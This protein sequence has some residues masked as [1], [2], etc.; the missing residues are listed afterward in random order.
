MI[1][2][3]RGREGGFTMVEL[4]IATAVLGLVMAGL[5][6]L[7][8]ASR[9][10]YLRGSNSAD[11]Q[12][13]V[14]AALERMGKEIREAG[15][16]PVTPDTSTST[17]PP[18]AGGL[19]PSAGGSANP[20]WSFYPIINQSATALTLQYDWNGDGAITTAGKVND[21]R[22]CP[23]GGTCRGEQITYS[24]SGLN[25]TRQEVG[26]AGGAQTLATNI[27]SLTFTYLDA[28]NNTTASRDLMRSVRVSITA[29]TGTDGSAATVTDQIRLRNR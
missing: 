17:C 3:R 15:Y 10:A 24:L 4:L 2:H 26:D 16:H 23:T 27:T 21:G 13:N 6:G 5:M 11:A 29:K 9:L 12:Q 25:L 28:N 14:R 8:N 22:L 1:V 20:C 18:G 7:I 19:Y